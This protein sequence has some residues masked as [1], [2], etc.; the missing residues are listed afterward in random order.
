MKNYF[1]QIKNSIFLVGKSVAL[2]Y[3]G[4][5]EESLKCCDE[6]I[7]LNPQDKNAWYGKGALSL[8]LG[9]TETFVQNEIDSPGIGYFFY[10]Y[11]KISKIN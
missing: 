7:K 5:Y 11:W 3:L 9:K 1:N 8:I 2:F 6:A 4:R 10:Y